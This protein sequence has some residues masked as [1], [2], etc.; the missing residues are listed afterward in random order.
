MAE[1]CEQE[2]VREG[3]K[4]EKAAGPFRHLSAETSSGLG[5]EAVWRPYSEMQPELDADEL[6]LV[7][8][9]ADKIE[10]QR[11]LSTGVITTTDQ[12]VWELDVPLSAKMVRTW[13]KKMK[14]EAEGTMWMRRSR[15]VG[16]DFNF[17]EYREDVYSPASSSAVVTLLPCMAL[18]DG[19]V[20]DGVLATLDVADAFLQ[21]PQTIPRK[22][23]LDGC[24]YIILKCLPGQRDASRLW[25]AFF[26]ERLKAHVPVEV[27]PEQPC[28]LKRGNDGVLLLHV[29]DVLICGCE[30]WISSVEPREGV[31]THLTYTMVKRQGGGSLEFLK[32][33]H[34][35]EPGFSSITVTAE[36]KRAS[37]MIERFSNIDGKLPRIA[38]TPTSGSLNLRDSDFLPP[39]RAA[40]YRSLVGIAMYL[41]QERF[42]LQ[43][44]TKTLASCLQQ[45]TRAAWGALGRLVGYLRLGKILV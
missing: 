19:F 8:V 20:K 9:E 24:E 2:C 38:F 15:L 22:I 26:V 16:R 21:V 3:S 7:D 33:N 27:C 30:E 28:I 29:D 41:A 5:A 32:R 17:L 4:Y 18:S 6:H 25:Y 37:A 35:I 42:D 43:Y 34:L 45:P 13:R 11:L 14:S 40:E 36:G 10:I 31:Q 12:Y 39:L 23:S 1:Y 44:A